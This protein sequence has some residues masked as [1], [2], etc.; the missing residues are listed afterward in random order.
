[1]VGVHLARFENQPRAVAMTRV[2]HGAGTQSL[3]PGLCSGY[4]AYRFWNS[5]RSASRRAFS[6]GSI[7]FRYHW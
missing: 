3:A 6:A 2:R 5:S 1:M 4:L 7:R